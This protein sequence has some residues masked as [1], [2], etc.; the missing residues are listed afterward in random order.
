MTY[1]RLLYI[2]NIDGNY[3]EVRSPIVNIPN[4]P[5]TTSNVSYNTAPAGFGG[6]S[7]SIANVEIWPGHYFPVNSCKWEAIPDA[8]PCDCIN[9]VCLPS[10]T[11]NTPGVFATIAACDAGC[12]K[13]SECAGEC[14]SA[15]ELNTLQRAAN[16]L[17]SIICG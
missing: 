3:Q 13:N 7:V 2:S 5:G 6:Y 17:Q 9:G 8:Y 11:Y 15:E 10:S 1:G 12:A 16:S 4:A 14:V